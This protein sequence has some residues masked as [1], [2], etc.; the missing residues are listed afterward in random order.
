MTFNQYI[1]NPMGKS[2]AVFSQ[3]EA[4]KAMYSEKF[5][6]VLVKENGTFTYNLFWDKGKDEFF[7]VMKVPS[8]STDMYYDV[9]IKFS[10]SNN[11]L[12]TSPVL[13]EYD[14][15][16]FSNDPAFVFTYLRVFYKNNML[17]EELK[18]KA[19]KKALK[20]D[21]VQRNAYQTPGYV[22]SIYFA[23]LYMKA[24]GLFQKNTY[25]TIGEAYNKTKLNSLVT[26]TDS[27]LAERTD[28]GKRAAA[29][30]KNAREKKAVQ[31]KETDA[32]T[33]DYKIKNVNRSQS[34]KHIKTVSTSSTVKNIS[35][36][37]RSKSV[38]KK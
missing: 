5:D 23:Y 17:I 30:R 9:V 21:P 37:R 4:F 1:D 12:R 14:V 26:D 13:S 16:F 24:K 8:E 6:K 33:A 2:N 22:K 27:K 19:S 10:T 31:R 20:D 35:Q 28:A 36:V 32:G 34:T 15:R 11:A 7:C 25:R 38:R 18:N 3:R 29:A